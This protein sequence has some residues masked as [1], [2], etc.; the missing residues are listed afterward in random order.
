ME[1]SRNVTELQV[2][3]T[4]SNKDQPAH[5]GLLVN[6]T[7][8]SVQ[9]NQMVTLP[10]EMLRARLTKLFDPVQLKA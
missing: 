4:L 7:I 10:S 9:Q 1:V 5:S 8:P 2:V 6:M 3:Y